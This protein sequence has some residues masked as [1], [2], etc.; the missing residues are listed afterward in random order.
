M[1]PSLEDRLKAI[2]WSEFGTAYGTAE[3]VADQLRRLAGSDRKDALAATHDLWCGLCHQHVQ[4]GSAAVPALP[5]ILEVL[6]TADDVMAVELL[7]IVLGFAKGVNRKRREKFQQWLGRKEVEE[8]PSWLAELRAL[9]S[10]ERPRFERLAASENDDIGGFAD[11][12][13]AE[14][15]ETGQ[16]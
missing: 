9:L 15:N 11:D 5:F 2:D 8:E 7:D 1:E 4:V 14:L 16:Q 13:L 6:D 12:I 3:G 10:A